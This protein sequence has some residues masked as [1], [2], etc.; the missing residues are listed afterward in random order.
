MNE[1]N[2]AV[3]KLQSIQK[4]WIELGRTRLNTPEYKKLIESIRVLSAE[5][6]AL[7]DAIKKPEKSK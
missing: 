1:T 5:Y 7:V 4:L 2:A 3:D 6:Q